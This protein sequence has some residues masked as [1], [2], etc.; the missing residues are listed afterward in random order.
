LSGAETSKIFVNNPKLLRDLKRKFHTGFLY[1]WFYGVPRKYWWVVPVAT[2][3][4]A[5]SQSMEEEK[6]K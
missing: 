2:I 5:A 1:R 4:V 6:K 3:A